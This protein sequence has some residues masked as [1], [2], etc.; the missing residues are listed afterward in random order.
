MG[1]GGGG[2]GDLYSVNTQALLNQICV[3]SPI[4]EN[5]KHAQSLFSQAQLQFSLCLYSA[6]LIVV[7]Q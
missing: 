1:L 7:V 4:I 2:G 3:F 6:H 5:L